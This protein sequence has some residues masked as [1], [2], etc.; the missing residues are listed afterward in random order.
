MITTR[1]GI[2]LNLRSV[3]DYFFFAKCTG[4]GGDL[5]KF[6]LNPTSER[7]TSAR[8][9]IKKGHR[10]SGSMMYLVS[11]GYSWNMEHDAR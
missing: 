8:P 9:L 10:E 2:M 11:N 1:I 3:G 5:P 6:S 4:F 7:K